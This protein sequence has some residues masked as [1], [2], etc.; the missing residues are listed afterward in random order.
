MDVRKEPSWGSSAGIV[1]NYRLDEQSLILSRGKQFSSSLCVQTRLKPTYPLIQ[2]VW[3]VLS[4]VVK[5]GWGVMLSTQP[6]LVHKSIMS[7]RLTFLYPVV[8]AWQ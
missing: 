3:G 4:P 6:H 1:S 5:H 2:W 7:T 8:T